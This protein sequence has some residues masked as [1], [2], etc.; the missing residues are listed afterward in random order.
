MALNYYRGISLYVMLAAS[1][2]G[3][4]AASIHASRALRG[5]AQ[6][7]WLINRYDNAL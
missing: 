5:A 2:S 6:T 1:I 3:R 4:I 7:G